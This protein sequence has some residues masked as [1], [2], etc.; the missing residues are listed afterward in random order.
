MTYSELVRS[1]YRR[2]VERFYAVQYARRTERSYCEFPVLSS[3]G[4]TIWF[5]Q[6]VH[7]L[8]EGDSVQGF[9]AVARNITER[10]LA[11]TELR[12]SEDRLNRLVDAAFEAVFLTE[13]GIIIDA[14]SRA[15]QMFGYARDE[16]IG[17]PGLQL[18]APSHR[19]YVHESAAAGRD[20]MYLSRCLRKDGSEFS[21]EVRARNTPWHGRVGR[22]AVLR[23]ITDRQRY[24]EEIEHQR[25][26]LQQANE[27][28]RTSNQR[29]TQLA[30]SDGLT[31]LKN[32]RAFQEALANEWSRSQRYNL[33]LSLLLIDVDHFKGF[34][35]SFGHPAGDEVL[36][37]VAAVLAS[38]VRD[39]DM[40]A[41]Y[42]GE[43]FAILQPN[44][45]GQDSLIQAERIR[46]AIVAERWALRPV[47]ISVGAAASRP[48][49]AP[50]DEAD[51][52]EDRHTAQELVQRA[53]R[54]L[55]LSKA[56]GR[57][58]VHLADEA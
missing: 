36:R 2:H 4:E 52:T 39:I 18:T 41:R 9:Q 29:L 16:L 6:H 27:E 46:K 55:Y 51:L 5:G 40:A 45:N 26:Q 1:D 23:D 35:D 58:C 15:C 38:N 37:R 19:N 7:L 57:N 14:N 48:L 34:N 17:K 43:E 49:R 33:P 3:E 32:H 12:E 50:Y 22:I 31:G 21:V 28:L 47:T 56:A 13:N 20:D 54:A 8:H 25:W 53:D 10:K 30:T 11:E 42:G 24:E 44:T